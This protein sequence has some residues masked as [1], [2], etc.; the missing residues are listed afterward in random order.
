MRAHG[1]NQG[2]QN[3]VSRFCQ[4]LLACC[5]RRNNNVMP[6]EPGRF[7]PR[8]SNRSLSMFDQGLQRQIGSSSLPNTFWHINSPPRLSEVK[9]PPKE[10]IK[11]TMPVTKEEVFV[12]LG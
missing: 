12:L 10:Y 9:L 4:K 3:R 5:K 2:E 7:V 6:Q 1:R 8:I 11:I